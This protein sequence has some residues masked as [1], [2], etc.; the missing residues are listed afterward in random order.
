MRTSPS[1]GSAKRG[2]R[3]A[4]VVLPQPLG[5]TMA[6]RLPE[7]DVQVDIADDRIARLVGETHVLEHQVAAVPA[8]RLRP[9]RLANV[10]LS[11]QHGV[12]PVGGGRR[13]LDPA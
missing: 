4:K 8:Q 12:N 11:I 5:P 9:L 6:I 1:V 13:L 2:I 7:L 3:L 10:R